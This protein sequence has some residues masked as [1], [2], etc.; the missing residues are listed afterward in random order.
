MKI[1]SFVSSVIARY[2]LGEVNAI[3]FPQLLVFQ[4]QNWHVGSYLWRS[5]GYICHLREK[6]KNVN[7]SAK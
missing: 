3:K 4:D 1:Y 2:P 6:K 5:S 7:I